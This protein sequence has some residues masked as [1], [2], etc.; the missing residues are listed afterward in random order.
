MH[1]DVQFKGCE[2]DILLVFF[3][4]YKKSKMPLT[5]I[6]PVVLTVFAFFCLFFWGGFCVF[7]GGRGGFRECIKHRYYDRL[8]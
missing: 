3:F 7:F 6:T 2:P 8:C 5:R 1:S 4:Y